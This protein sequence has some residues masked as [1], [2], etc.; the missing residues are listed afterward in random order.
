VQI[1]KI[2][3]K[4]VG[5]GSLFLFLIFIGHAVV[6]GHR[7]AG[8]PS[9]SALKAGTIYNPYFWLTFLI[10]YGTAFWVVRRK[11]NA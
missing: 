3:L 2:I 1:L 8:S 6:G 7:T 11:R 4:I 10:A 9:L 5:L